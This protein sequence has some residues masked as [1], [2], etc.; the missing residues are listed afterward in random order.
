[1]VFATVERNRDYLREW[2]PWVDSTRSAQDIREFIA[3]SEAKFTVSQAPDAGIWIGGAFGGSI[4]C[5]QID[6]ANRHTSIG[7]WID[8]A[9][10]RKGVMTCCSIAMLDYLFEDLMLHRVEI[11]CATGNHRSCAIPQR[12]GFT[13]EGVAHEAEWVNDRWLDLVVWAMTAGDWKKTEALRRGF[14]ERLGGH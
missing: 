6:W 10:Q 9:Q 3:R 2:L 7:Y 13:R 14:V 1:M 12:L 8:R 4:G 5:H 11:R